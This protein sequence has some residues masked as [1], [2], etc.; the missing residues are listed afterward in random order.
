MAEI[1]INDK[2]LSQFGAMML[3]G[4]YASLLTPAELKEWVFNDDPRKNGIEYIQP[5]SPKVKERSIDLIFGI[6]GDTERDFL[7]KYNAFIG[8][9]HKA[10]IK[11]YVPDM[12]RYYYLKY[13]NFTSFD[14]FSLKACK[15]AIKF[16]EPDP[17]KTE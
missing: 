7:S 4:S 9:L 16:I 15:V 5:E 3:A 14:N 1:K 12:E 11:L 6:K 2:P 10:I 8:E 17:T 13:S